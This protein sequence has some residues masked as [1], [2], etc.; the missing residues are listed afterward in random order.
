MADFYRMHRDSKAGA[1]LSK[2]FISILAIFTAYLICLNLIACVMYKAFLLAFLV[3]PVF[4]FIYYISYKWNISP[5][6]FIIAIFVLAF[7]SKGILVLLTDT[8]PVSDFNTFYQNAVRLANGDKTFSKTDYFRTWA[9]QTGPVMYYALI[10]KLFGTALLP[11][12]LV[13]CFFMAITNT[14][15]YLTA[16]KMS[17]E[18]AARFAALLYL[19]YPAP[20]FLAGVLT[21]QHF[22]ACMLLAGIYVLTLEQLNWGV[23]GIIAGILISL[24]NAVRPLGIIIISAAVIWGIIEAV[25]LKKA[26]KVCV[27]VLL[28]VTYLTVNFGISTVVKRTD[29]NSEGLVNNFPM[30]KF[31]LGF[32]EKSNGQFSFDD[33][34]KIFDIHDFN[35]RNLAAKQALKQ[36]LSIGAPRLAKL[37]NMKQAVMWAW[38][39]TLRWGFYDQVKGGALVAPKTLKKYEPY[40]LGT[41]KIYYILVFML[42]LSGLIY[43]LKNQKVNNG[44]LLLTIVLLCYF[45]AHFLIE[46]QVRYRYFAVILVFIIAAKGSEYLFGRF[47]DNREGKYKISDI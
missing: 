29:I 27:I 21:N 14:F 37:M 30:W 3:I 18:Y 20:Y 15:I 31:V 10:M 12:K 44:I 22:A 8:K 47:K 33:Q 16:R 13:N 24:G 17:S 38:F 41:E 36:R 9:Y 5:I 26:G 6:A 19:L 32:N 35:K 42:M 7:L 4:I 43:S 23:K 46:V 39:D 25:R 45:G 40:I 34:Y 28:V 1:I 2:G 11:L